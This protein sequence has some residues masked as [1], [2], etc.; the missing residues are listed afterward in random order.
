[1][2]RSP[3][4]H[5]PAPWLRNAATLWEIGFAAPQVIAQRTARMALA[6][7]SPSARDRREFA[8]MGLEKAEAFHESWLAMGWRLWQMQAAA[9]TQWWG[10]WLRQ[11]PQMALAAE[12]P[13][14]QA[15]PQILAS[16]LKPVHR[17]VTANAKRLVGTSTRRGR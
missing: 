16:G 9:A 12:Q 3:R 13:L 14:L 1:M 8:R 11:G 7:H 2:P 15:W 17:R 6:G 4:P 5:D 10:Q